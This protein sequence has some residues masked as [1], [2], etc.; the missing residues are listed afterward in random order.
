MIFAAVDICIGAL[1]AGVVRA[2]FGVRALLVGAKLLIGRR[3]FVFLSFYGG[4]DFIF[5]VWNS[6]PGF[7]R[8]LIGG[9]LLGQFFPAEN[10]QVSAVDNNSL[11]FHDLLV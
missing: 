1:R 3:H 2:F 7:S 10:R 6:V 4:G 9:G 8:Q 11:G 5:H